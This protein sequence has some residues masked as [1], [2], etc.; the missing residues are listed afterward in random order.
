MINSIRVAI[1]MVV[2][3]G[4][5]FPGRRMSFVLAI[6]AMLLL[7]GCGVLIA[8]GG[9]SYGEYQGYAG[10]PVSADKIATLDWSDC[11]SSYQV[12]CTV[13]VNR[14]GSEGPPEDVIDFEKAVNYSRV[15]LKPTKYSVR[16]WYAFGGSID[17]DNKISCGKVCGTFLMEPG[18]TYVVQVKRWRRANPSY[19]PA[20]RYQSWYIED[21]ETGKAVAGDPP[22]KDSVPATIVF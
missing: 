14:P 17:P 21:K 8:K 13:A 12:G 19:W 7:G 18:H 4:P 20:Q 15:S 2:P 3:G 5:A 6:S 10:P 16:V 1:V 9:L 11:K 22:P